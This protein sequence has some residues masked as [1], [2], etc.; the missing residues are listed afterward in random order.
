MAGPR[1]NYQHV[2]RVAGL[3]AA[4]FVAFVVVRWAL[5]PADFGAYGFYRGGALTDARAIPVKYGGEAA[6]VDC[7]SEA[8][9]ARKGARHEKIKCE[10][11]HGPLASHA[12]GDETAKPRALNPRLLCLQCHTQLQGQPSTF[13]KVVPADHGG[14]GPCTECHKPHRPSIQSNRP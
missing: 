3:F 5:V 9:E 8:D 1:S 4:G 7:H 10:A 6:C 11:C 13:P 14:D 12:T 2:F